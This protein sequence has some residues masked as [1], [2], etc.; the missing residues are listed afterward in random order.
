MPMV[1]RVGRLPIQCRPCKRAPGA[2]CGLSEAAVPGHRLRA[3]AGVAEP[4]QVAQVEEQVWVAAVRS[5]VI[6]M[7]C[8][9]PAT[10][11]TDRLRDQ[12][13]LPQGRPL[14]C[15]VERVRKNFF[16]LR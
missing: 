15:A 16:V 10:Q 11:Y 3:V 5:D 8:R 14:F 1:I 2:A 4:L 9:R 7:G 6:D 13:L 12:N